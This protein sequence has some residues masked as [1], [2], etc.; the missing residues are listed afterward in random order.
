M[1]FLTGRADVRTRSLGVVRLG[2]V[3]VIPA[4]PG[5]SAG[6]PGQSTAAAGFRPARV[7]ATDYLNPCEFRKT[8][9][10]DGTLARVV[11]RPCESGFLMSGARQR[12]RGTGSRPSRTLE[13]GVNALRAGCLCPFSAWA[14]RV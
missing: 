12:K 4:R 5:L 1:G 2:L 14:S 3:G 8:L 10:A 9:A 13:T 7:D 11:R 6:R